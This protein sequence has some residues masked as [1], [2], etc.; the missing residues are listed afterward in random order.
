MICLVNLV[1]LI[2]D[3]AVSK[4]IRRT[5]NPSPAHAFKRELSVQDQ[6]KTENEETLDKQAAYIE[7]L[8]DVAHEDTCEMSDMSKEIREEKA[9]L[10]LVNR[11][12]LKLQRDLLK[13][14]C[15]YAEKL[16]AKQARKRSLSLDVT[17]KSVT[18]AK[19]KT[20][21]TSDGTTTKD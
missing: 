1:Y 16:A 7:E 3:P 19:P 14:T 17:Q 12:H 9:K 5:R 21:A 10:L 11:E 4:N 20:S 6:T 8:S 18:E 13:C 2:S 15:N